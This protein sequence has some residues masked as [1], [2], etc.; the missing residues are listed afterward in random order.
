MAASEFYEDGAYQF[1]GGAKSAA[2]MID[3]LEALVDEF[4]LVSIEDGLDEA[5]WDGWT[6]LTERLGDR[7]QL[8]GDDLFVTNEEILRRGIAEKSANAILI[9]VNQIGS[10]SETLHT[11][12]TAEARLVRAHGE[13][14]LGRDRGHLH[15]SSGGGH[16]RRADQDR[17][18]HPVRA[19]GQV[20]PVAPHR[21]APRYAGTV[22][23]LVH[24]QREPMTARSRFQTM[25]P[26]LLLVVL[27]VVL[28]N[29][30]PFRQMM[31][32]EQTIDLARGRLLALQAENS[33]LE[34]EVEALGTEQELE[35]MARQDLGYVMPGETSYVITT[36]EFPDAPAPVQATL[37]ERR[38]WYAAVWDF[39]TGSDLVAEEL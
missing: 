3:Y 35:R 38:P 5:D 16:Q 21:G 30:F 18:A 13:P 29:I 9:K 33:R 14:S 7:I 1:E 24:L 4:P 23:R 20:Q 25:A 27:A 12:A 11:M 2:E 22:R 8:V 10:L 15:R 26:V 32:N 34:S 19:D 37:P 6:A 17:R 39:L 31:A 28:T 36:P